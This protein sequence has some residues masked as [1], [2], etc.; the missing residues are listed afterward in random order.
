MAR[1]DIV[2]H[3]RLAALIGSM[4][5]VLGGA[6]RIE[7][8]PV[9][10]ANC[11]S[12]GDLERDISDV[13]Y[14][15]LWLFVGGD[16]PA[17][18]EPPEGASALDN[19]DCDGD[20]ARS[21]NDAV[22]L[23]QWLF[24]GGAAPK[25]SL[26]GPTARAE[27]G[28]EGGSLS[29]PDGSLTL[30]I[31]AGALESPTEIS[32]AEVPPD[33]VPEHLRAIEADRVYKLGPDGQQFL[34]PVAVTLSLAG[35]NE[36]AVLLTDSNGTTELAAEQKVRLG[37]GER[38]LSGQLRHFSYTAAR[39]VGGFTVEVSVNTRRV[40]VG[41][42]VE[43]T[44]SV[45]GP[46]P[47]PAY[48]Y[49]DPLEG[50][51]FDLDGVDSFTGVAECERNTRNTPRSEVHLW[52]CFEPGSETLSV[53]YTVTVTAALRRFLPNLPEG[54]TSIFVEID[55]VC[56]DDPGQGIPEGTTPL[57]FGM[58]APDYLSLFSGP[59]ASIFAAAGGAGEGGGAG[60]QVGGPYAAIAGA[61]GMVVMD[62]STRLS[63][64]NM[65][66]QSPIG[67]LGSSLLGVQPISRPNPGPDSPAAVAGVSAGF[68][69]SGMRN[70]VTP[71]GVWGFTLALLQPTLDAATSGGGLVADEM[72]I[73]FATRG[74]GFVRYQEEPQLFGFD[75]GLSIDGSLFSEIGGSLRS[76]VL[77]E[78]GAGLPVLGLSA[79]TD[80]G[81][82]STL[83]AHLRQAGQQ[84]L[85]LATLPDPDARRLRC[86]PEAQAP[87]ALGGRIPAMATGFTTAKVW[88][89]LY[90]PAQPA[91]APQV[92]ELDAGAGALGVQF[93]LRSSGLPWAVVSNFNA[94]SMTIFLFDAQGQLT[95]S[96]TL[97]L[98][99]G[100]T[101]SGHA[102]PFS[103]GGKDYIAGTCYDNGS[104]F[105]R[106]YTGGPN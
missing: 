66:F 73:T 48:C 98:P 49:V 31:P 24:R 26:L 3:I 29:S 1:R 15:L 67:G 30:T 70:W 54:E 74:L 28:A 86:L 19:G 99:E 83:W 101:K 42:T 91:A 17:A 6:A 68:G 93:G 75:T 55:V 20:G 104:Y 52:T 105:V 45:T 43:A 96:E 61:N 8:A 14:L 9:A 72:V 79:G 106:S 89:F 80:N 76:A 69:G 100:C 51:S 102:A 34:Q 92:Q 95:G 21:L 7:A 18:L 10:R 40:K 87:A 57:P 81:T 84:A 4:M 97:P 38:L 56:E 41:G 11:D 44:A 2:R 60:G 65:T 78:A 25:E 63:A 82:T 94:G 71:D 39:T 13:V 88:Y 90:D 62:L 46:V 36:L 12:N 64:L 37:A 58:T 85:E 103:H 22:Y 35:G 33:K 32:I 27:L 23:L 47:V 5:G 53:G 16:A 59:W 77:P 50:N